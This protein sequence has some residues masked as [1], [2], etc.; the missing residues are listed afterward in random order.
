MSEGIKNKDEA[1]ALIESMIRAVNGLPVNGYQSCLLIVGLVN[2]LRSVSDFIDKGA[3]E[4]CT[5]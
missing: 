1:K 4:E 2:D 3:E 5:M